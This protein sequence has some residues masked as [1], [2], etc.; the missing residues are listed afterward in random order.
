MTRTSEFTAPSQRSRVS[1]WS[2]LLGLAI[3]LLALLIVSNPGLMRYEAARTAEQA[4]RRLGAYKTSLQATILRHQY[5]SRI[6]AEDPRLV[7]P[8]REIV[9]HPNTLGLDINHSELLTR[10]N[11]TA[12]SDEIFVMDRDGHTHWSSNYQSDNS[13]VGQN[14]G[15]RPYFIDAMSGRQGFYYAVG[16]T[17]GKPGLFFANA[18]RSGT[19]ILGVI[20]VKIDL[21]TLEQSWQHSGDRV[22]VTD[23]NGIIFLASDE[24]WHYRSIASISRGV[25]NQLNTTLQYGPEPIDV[26]SAADTVLGEQFSAFPSPEG[27]QLVNFPSEVG[28]YPWQMHWLVPLEQIQQRVRT[29]QLAMVLVFLVLSGGLLYS[30][31]RRRR[32]SAQW[33]LSRMTQERESHQRAIIQNTDAGLLNL[34]ANY[35]PLFINEKARDLFLL[36]DEDRTATPSALLSPWSPETAGLHSVRAEGVRRNGQRFPLLY[37]LKPIRMGAATEYI[38]TVQDVTELTEA[39]VALQEANEALERRVEA[40][41]ADLQRAQAALAQNQK[42]AALGRMSAAIAHEINQPITALGNYAAS[43]RLLLEHQQTEQVASNL[44]KI[45]SL[46]ERLSGLSRQLR[47]FSGKRNTGSEWVSLQGPV[48]YALDVLRSRL[49]EH[50]IECR[51]AIDEAAQVQANTMMLEQIVV[52]LMANAIDA[53]TGQADAIIHIRLER[54]ERGGLQLT[55][56]DNGPGMSAEQQAKI[57]EP[58]YTTKAVGEGV[59]LGL[60]ISYSLAL[61]MEAQLSVNSEPGQGT[62]FT[63]H[64]PHSRVVVPTQPQSESF[65]P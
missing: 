7:V 1:L 33:A 22:W 27:N 60:A 65:T 3:A 17:S 5:L 49:D 15:F 43:S 62:R 24:Y 45:E 40:R 35:R 4:E 46:L 26:M 51:I 6:L 18:I 8:L 56:D 14:Y 37:T 44:G 58:F 59:G 54:D 48:R 28:F 29:Q 16:A 19:D 47:I 38:L 52:N 41:T 34:D 31:E 32:T 36:N 61:D 10:I 64:F 30:R 21:A 50:A 2:V 25:Q 11:A 39:Q 55:L 53:L 63:L 23:R 20:V 57:F 12:G 9:R 13:F 42:L